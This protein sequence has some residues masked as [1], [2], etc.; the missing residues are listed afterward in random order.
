MPQK[1][2][3]IKAKSRL[4]ALSLG[5][6]IGT[7]FLSAVPMTSFEAN[8][9]D[10]NLKEDPFQE[11]IFSGDTLNPSILAFTPIFEE[12]EAS[13]GTPAINLQNQ[14]KSKIKPSPEVYQTAYNSY[15]D[16]QPPSVSN[17]PGSTGFDH[18]YQAAGTK[19]GVPWQILSA[20]HYKETK[21]SGNSGIASY[22]GAQG[23]MQFIPSTF[24]RFG[25]DGDGDGRAVISDVEDAIFS[26]A[27]YLAKSG[28]NRGAITSALYAYNHSSAYVGSVLAIARGLGYQG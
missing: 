5:F 21:R 15:R 12:E 20:V 25:V 24:R 28:A 8:K 10:L 13:G 1:S 6:F 17:N 26:A 22:A 2:P 27:N 9:K 7:P 19:Y 11:E 4:F 18:I 14:E 23:P 16:P 3:K